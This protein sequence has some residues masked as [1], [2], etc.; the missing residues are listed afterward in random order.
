MGRLTGYVKPLRPRNVC[1][2]SVY[3]D[4]QGPYL[5][6]ANYQYLDHVLLQPLVPIAGAPPHL[7]TAFNI[8][9]LIAGRYHACQ[10][11][12]KP[13]ADLLSRGEL[14]IFDCNVE[15]SPHLRLRMI[16]YHPGWKSKG[17]SRGA[18]GPKS[19]IQF[20]EGTKVAPDFVEQFEHPVNGLACDP[21]CH[22]IQLNSEH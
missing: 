6:S 5:L 16:F 4:D 14:G 18:R 21:K 19:C 8:A 3:M 13:L 17:G 1:G 9:W 11:G 12:L 10:A 22:H 7:S 20:R 15:G 2:S